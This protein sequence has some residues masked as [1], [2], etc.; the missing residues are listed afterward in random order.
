MISTSPNPQSMPLGITPIRNNDL[1][2]HGTPQPVDGIPEGDCRLGEG[3]SPSPPDGATA[4]L[5]R[6]FSTMTGSTQEDFEPIF[7]VGCPRSGTT[8]LTVLLDRHDQIAMPPETHF[9]LHLPWNWRSAKY[10]H[11]ELV[12]YFVDQTHMWDMKL[13]RDAVLDRF[14]AD[15]PTFPNFFRRALEEFG[16]RSGKV[17]PGEKSPVHLSYIPRIVEMYPEA[18]ILWLVRDGRDSVMAILRAPDF[19]KNVRRSSHLW[20]RTILEGLR[21]ERDWPRNVLRVHFE[22]LLRNPKA[23]MERVSRFLGVEFQ[24]RQLDSGVQ[25]GVVMT[26][27]LNYKGRALGQLDLSKIGEYRRQATPDQLRV[28]DAI[29]SRALRTMG[30]ESTEVGPVP[31]WRRATDLAMDLP[32]YV[33]YHPR[34]FLLWTE[35]R[36]LWAVRIPRRGAR[37]TKAVHR[38]N[39]AV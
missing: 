34:V 9:F 12:D 3:A 28:M 2:G 29:M 25:S 14:R 19:P 8:L 20:R 5:T 30:Y 24:E 27:E 31:W 4:G 7:I 6:G 1:H 32:L 11:E 13:D 16:G 35:L 39:T 26:K 38:A 36:K 10:T 21:H 22:E 18:K 15:E 17:Q 33:L 37:G 23:E